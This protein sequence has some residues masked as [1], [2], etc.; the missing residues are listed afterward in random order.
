MQAG[1]GPGLGEVGGGKWPVA[2]EQVAVPILVSSA[3]FEVAVV[4]L[5]GLLLLAQEECQKRLA[6]VV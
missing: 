3:S 1:P 5:L 2:A 6:I 4:L